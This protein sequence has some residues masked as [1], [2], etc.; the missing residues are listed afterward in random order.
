VRGKDN[1]VQ[2]FD[3]D[4]EVVL[5]SRQYENIEPI[6]GLHTLGNKKIVVSKTGQIMIDNLSN[7]MTEEIYKLKGEHVHKT[8]LRDTRLAVCSKGVTLQIWD[9]NS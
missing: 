9:V 6:A 4:S 3:V 1:I 8:Y 2:S 7:K 5:K